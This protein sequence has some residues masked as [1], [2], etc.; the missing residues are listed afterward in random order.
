MLFGTFAV[1]GL[2][3]PTPMFGTRTWSPVGGGIP[4]PVP[5]NYGAS[6][7]APVATPWVA[8]VGLPLPLPTAPSVI[9]GTTPFAV[10]CVGYGVGF[11]A[12]PMVSP[13]GIPFA[14][15]VP[16]VFGIAGC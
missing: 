2:T 3:C 14:P 16:A 6:L 12:A 7:G 15:G 8:G 13:Y 10:P 11:P 9:P 1:P 4:L 5:G